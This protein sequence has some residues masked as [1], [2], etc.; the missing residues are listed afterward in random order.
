MQS[1]SLA[2]WLVIVLYLKGFRFGDLFLITAVL[3]LPVL[4]FSTS[5]NEGLF[6]TKC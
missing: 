6:A 3:M 5:R 1:L 4:K 2:V